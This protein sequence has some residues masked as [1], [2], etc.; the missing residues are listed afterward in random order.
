MKQILNKAKKI[1]IPPKKLENDI[2]KV[3][4]F[5]FNLVRKEVSNYFLVDSL[6]LT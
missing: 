4:K 2:S 3:A 5:T 1:V 6:F